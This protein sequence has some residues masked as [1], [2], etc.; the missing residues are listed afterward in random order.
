MYPYTGISVS[1]I[2]EKTNG[3]IFKSFMLSEIS[4]TKGYIL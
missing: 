1:N 4:Q 3:S 2:N